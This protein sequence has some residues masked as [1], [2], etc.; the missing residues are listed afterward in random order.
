V[1]QVLH[2]EMLDEVTCVAHRRIMGYSV[3]S[4][5]MNRLTACFSKRWDN[6]RATLA[7]FF[8][9][10]NYCRQ[11]ATLKGHTP[12]KAHGL[13]TEVW[14]VHKM[15]K[16][17]TAWMS[18]SIREIRCCD[19]CGCNYVAATSQMYK[20]CPECAHHLYGYPG[21]E[22]EFDDGQCSKCRWD[23]IALCAPSRST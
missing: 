15:L 18:D 14:S 17:V 19:E 10:Y 13:T 23:G 2:H 5:R 20:L 8:C 4:K 1:R 6:H 22:H 9:R 11:H 16:V 12:A 21:C 7:M 3:V